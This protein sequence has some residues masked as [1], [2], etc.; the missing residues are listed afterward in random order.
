MDQDIDKRKMALSTTIPPTLT[1]PYVTFGSSEH[2]RC[3]HVKV[4][5]HGGES[6]PRLTKRF[7]ELWSPNNKV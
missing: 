1:L 7:G 4:A 3:H 2:K 6:L 5:D